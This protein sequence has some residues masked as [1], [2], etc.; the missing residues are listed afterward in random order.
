MG[1][2]GQYLLTVMSTVRSTLRFFRLIFSLKLDDDILFEATFFNRICP[3]RT[4]KGLKSLQQEF[5]NRIIALDAQ[6]VAPGALTW[7]PY[8]PDLNP[9][10]YFLW[11]CLKDK[12]FRS[13]PA[14]L[15]DLKTQIQKEV[16]EIGKDAE[17][18]GKV[19]DNFEL[20]LR[21]LVAASG[22]HFENL[23]H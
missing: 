1:L 8:S 11:G 23:I 16:A 14:S 18:L 10:D 7:P 2:L 17:L 3:H 19:F 13:K 15:N 6:K 4:N 20:R 21:H 5:G 12:I 22:A 9:C